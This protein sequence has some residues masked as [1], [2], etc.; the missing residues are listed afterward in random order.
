MPP[1]GVEADEAGAGPTWFI[2]DG[3]VRLCA[4]IGARGTTIWIACAAAIVALTSCRRLPDEVYVPADAFRSRIEATTPQGRSATV[5][6]GEWLTLSVSRTSGPWVRVRRAALAPGACWLAPAPPD[7]EAQVADNVTWTAA[8]NGAAEFDVGLR[9][10]HRR[11]VRFARS[12]RRPRGG[13]LRP[14]SP[15]R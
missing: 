12:R 9:E 1:R 4:G 13:T 11:R 3:R 8:P 2:Y 15:R 5:R 14:R 6:A 7:H 10:D